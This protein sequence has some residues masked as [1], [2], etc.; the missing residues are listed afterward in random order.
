MNAQEV[1][2]GIEAA[3]T[4]GVVTADA[5]EARPGRGRGP[6]NVEL[7]FWQSRVAKVVGPHVTSSDHRCR[8]SARTDGPAFLLSADEFP[9]FV[10]R[11]AWRPL[12]T[13]DRIG[14]HLHHPGVTLAI[15]G[16]G[17]ARE[18]RGHHR[19]LD[20]TDQLG[21]VHMRIPADP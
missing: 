11:R 1:I 14:A 4:I 3:L 5:V 6:E 2:A 19:V 12:V 9:Q 8:V 18:C 15:D 20:H 13:A 17:A 10:H 21:W 16:K 7:R